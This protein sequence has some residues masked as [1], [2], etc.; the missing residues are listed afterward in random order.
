MTNAKRDENSVPTIIGV[1]DTDG[2][3]IVPIKIN[4]VNNRLKVSDGTTGSDNGTTN[5]KRDENSVVAKIA[6]SS[7]DGKTPITLYVDSSGNLLI[8]ST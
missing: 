7:S 2:S 8:Q 5:A 6:V 3:T 1:L 4:P